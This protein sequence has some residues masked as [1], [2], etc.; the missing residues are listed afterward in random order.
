VKMNIGELISINTLEDEQ[1]IF[2]DSEKHTP[3]RDEVRM[4]SCV[5]QGD[6]AQLFRA[7]GSID[8]TINTG[9]MSENDIVQSKYIAVS[10]ITLATRYAIQGGLDEKTAYSFSDEAIMKIDGLTDKDGIFACLGERM[11]TLTKMVGDS[12]KKPKRSPYIKKCVFY[13]NENICKKITVG[14]IAE[15][16]GISADYLSQLFKEEIGENLSS[17]ILR[18][19]T[20]KAKEYLISGMTMK[21]ISTLLGFSSQAHFSASFK[22]YSGLTP[23]EF[24]NISK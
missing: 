23:K 12:R 18:R 11:L 21:E 20:E 9:K 15:F 19:K 24:C 6:V 17:Y 4:L 5:Q 13:I 1:S 7:L 16:C 10:T 2:G 22:K 8:R 3:Y 14:E